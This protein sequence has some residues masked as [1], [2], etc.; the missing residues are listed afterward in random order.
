M[1]GNSKLYLNLS[2]LKSVR[3][4]FLTQTKILYRY[5]DKPSLKRV[6]RSRTPTGPRGGDLVN[7]LYIRSALIIFLVATL[8][9]ACGGGGK[10]SS[11]DAP[12]LAK[13]GIAN[14]TN[15][16]QICEVVDNP[17]D[18]I[19][20]VLDIPICDE[21]NDMSNLT[22]QANNQGQLQVNLTFTSG[23]L[24]YES[25]SKVD[26]V[27]HSNISTSDLTRTSFPLAA[28][29]LSNTDYLS[30][31]LGNFTFG[32]HIIEATIFHSDG[33][34]MLRQTKLFSILALPEDIGNLT[35]NTDGEISSHN[36]T[37]SS[38]RTTNVK[39]PVPPKSSVTLDFSQ[40]DALFQLLL[41]SPFNLFDT[42][43]DGKLE[44]FHPAQLHAL[45]HQ[46]LNLSEPMRASYELTADID[47]SRYS[48]WHPIGNTTNRF[49]GTFDGNEHLIS[50]L[51]SYGYD[52]AGLF[53]YLYRATISNIRIQFDTIEGLKSA[54]GLAGRVRFGEISNAEITL[55]DITVRTYDKGLEYSSK[56]VGGLIG[57]S[58]GT[59]LFNNSVRG[60][61]SISAHN[62][63]WPSAELR[64]GGLAG[65]ADSGRIINNSVEGEIDIAAYSH[66]MQ[67]IVRIAAFIG[68]SYTGF[69][70]DANINITGSISSF[71]DAG[72]PS[73]NSLG[74]ILGLIENAYLTNVHASL[75]STSNA[76]NVMHSSDANMAA[77]VGRPS[78]TSISNINV[79]IQGDITLTSDDEKVDAWNF[80]TNIK[81]SID[82][83][84]NINVIIEGDINLDTPYPSISSFTSVSY[85]DDDVNDISVIMNGDIS[86]GN[87][88]SSAQSNPMDSSQVEEG[89]GV[90]FSGLCVNECPYEMTNVSLVINGDIDLYANNNKVYWATMFH[91][92]SA[93][94]IHEI[95]QSSVLING[96]VTLE[97]YESDLYFE[98]VGMTNYY[99]DDYEVDLLLSINN[100]YA[101]IT[102]PT[103]INASFA[104]SKPP[105]HNINIGIL[106]RI[107]DPLPP[108]HII[109]SYIAMKEP[110]AIYV[111]NELSPEYFNASV[112]DAT[113]I[114]NVNL[115]NFYHSIHPP[116]QSSIQSPGS[117][118]SVDSQSTDTTYRDYVQLVCPTG[119]TQN[120]GGIPSNK[121]TYTN[122]DEDIWDFGNNATLPQL[123]SRY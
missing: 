97:L 78:S 90:Y 8:L 47:L 116:V 53:G 123:R 98:G 12:L 66:R 42:D 25:V 89:A 80:V 54:G 33:R 2:H 88:P 7:A 65:H 104:T 112:S 61:G 55:G 92:Y 5:L 39:P 73:R 114:R 68:H 84:T 24:Q 56:R 91:D 10:S 50:G 48:N 115:E 106:A 86:M 1:R 94:N 72:Y 102:G 41:H 32:Q 17:G 63:D 83:V 77:V 71:S 117:G 75:R 13:E 31:D 46:Q 27:I 107:D 87:K 23:L 22:D 34:P 58:D 113:P 11:R 108:I 37:V 81:S 62:L 21:D 36:S 119:P 103:T 4:L 96:S 14:P 28:D 101:H 6:S 111:N 105:S 74:V 60:A 20:A 3:V 43:G 79:Y 64:I 9:A 85:I 67:S 45:S 52:Y 110:L 118:P 18:S 35:S 100:S 122:W 76:I 82:T 70:S 26:F 109:N 93:R 95:D 44:I 59:N 57:H 69:I 30:F 120:C 40:D 38:N 99:D 51:S 15:N 29:V 49:Y 19:D 16:S 121:F